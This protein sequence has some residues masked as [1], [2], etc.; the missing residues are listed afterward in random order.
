MKRSQDTYERPDGGG[1]AGGAMGQEGGGVVL[2]TNNLTSLPAALFARGQMGIG[3]DQS[4][5]YDPLEYEMI[6][7]KGII[8]IKE[9]N[10]LNSLL[11]FRL[12]PGGSNVTGMEGVGTRTHTQTHTHARTHAHTHT[13]TDKGANTS[14]L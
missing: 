4:F 9:K 10:I 2:V 5:R 8:L 3:H 14:A 6:Y 13:C 7:L 12:G 11:S 1:D